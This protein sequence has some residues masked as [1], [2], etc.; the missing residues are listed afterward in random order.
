M[1]PSLHAIRHVFIPLLLEQITTDGN[2]QTFPANRD[3]ISI[4]HSKEIPD[5]SLHD[6]VFRFCRYT[7]L[8]L[9]CLLIAS[10]Y[11]GRLYD[12]HTIRIDSYSI[13]RLILCA[14]VASRKFHIDDTFLL[15]SY[16]DIGGVSVHELRNLEVQFCFSLKWK[17]HVS[18]DKY[19]EIFNLYMWYKRRN[20]N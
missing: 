16:A 3:Q 20:D 13:H 5:I 2:L 10:V 19:R 1:C 18:F 7:Q 8:P 12:T 11:L 4:Y 9:P 17:F 14:L 6:Y 15:K